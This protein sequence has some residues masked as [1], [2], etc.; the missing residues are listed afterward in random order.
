MGIN[1]QPRTSGSARTYSA[2]GSS[3]PGPRWP[4]VDRFCQAPFRQL[5]STHIIHY[6]FSLF[7]FVL[8]YDAPFRSVFCF[9]GL[10]CCRRSPIFPPANTSSIFFL[11][12]VPFYH[13]CRPPYRCHYR[14]LYCLPVPCLSPPVQSLQVAGRIP[15]FPAAAKSSHFASSSCNLAVQTNLLT[16]MNAEFV[17]TR[18]VHCE[19]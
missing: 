16:V 19:K 9:S 3:H 2:L 18:R 10:I 11:A 13:F 6:A 5:P 14:L 1:L 12:N 8:F 7:K 17:W 15:A 4:L